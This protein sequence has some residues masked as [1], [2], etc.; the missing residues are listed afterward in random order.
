M[1]K[2]YIIALIVTVVF[3]Q[4]YIYLNLAV[5]YKYEVDLASTHIEVSKIE[6]KIKQEKIVMIENRGKA[7]NKQ[8]EYLTYT[9]ILS[10]ILFVFLVNKN[11]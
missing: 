8:Q 10:S 3:I 1:K 6:K 4:I 11:R 5:S 9:I 2:N 7:I